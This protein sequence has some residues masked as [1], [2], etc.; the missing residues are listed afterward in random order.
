MSNLHITLNIILQLQALGLDLKGND[1]DTFI[2]YDNLLKDI[3]RESLIY[4]FQL[5]ISKS[6]GLSI[7]IIEFVDLPKSLNIRQNIINLIQETNDEPI[8][9]KFLNSETLVANL[10]H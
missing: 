9:I 2:A 8:E 4:N 10:N 5:P 3:N 1:N 7:L 6:T